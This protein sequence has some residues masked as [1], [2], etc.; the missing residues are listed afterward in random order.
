MTD[1]RR[2]FKRVSL[3]A[4]CWCEGRDSTFY[5]TIHD[6]SPGG[7]FIRTPTPFHTGT[8]VKVR[9]TFKRAVGEHEALME[10]VWKREAEPLPGMG[11]KFI[12]V[13]GETISILKQIVERNAEI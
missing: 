4:R 11:L 5:V 13:S 12:Q 8:Q 9:W 1:E 7:F 10:V 3:R 2:K 6:V